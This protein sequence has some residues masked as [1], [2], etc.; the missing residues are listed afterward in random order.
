MQP[1]HGASELHAPVRQP[2]VGSDGGKK[3]VEIANRSGLGGGTKGTRGRREIQGG[4]A[5]SAAYSWSISKQ[6]SLRFILTYSLNV[7][8]SALARW[9]Q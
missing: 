5:L 8:V 9:H 1:G 6:Q 7:S 4:L 3:E 2:I